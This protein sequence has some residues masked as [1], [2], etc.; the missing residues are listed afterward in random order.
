MKVFWHCHR[1]GF[2]LGI[3]VERAIEESLDLVDDDV[4]ALARGA[5]PLPRPSAGAGGASRRPCARCTSSGVL[6]PLSARVGRARPASCSTTSTTSSPPTSTRCSRWRTSRR[7]RPGQ[8]AESEG[9]ARGA[10]R[11]GAAGPPD[12]RHAAARHRQG[13][14]P[15]PRRQGHPAHRGADRAHRAARRRRGQGRSSW[16]RITSRMSHTAQRRDIDDPKT[17]EALAEVVR[18]A[19]AAAHALPP[20]L[21]RHARGGAGG[22]DGLAGAHPGELYQPHAGPA[23]RRAARAPSREAVAERV[24]GRPCAG[25]GSRR[26]VAA[27]LAMMSERY[28]ATTSPQ[29]IAAHLRLVERLEEDVGRHRALPPSRS[30][31]PSELVIA[32]RD[33]PGL[34]SLIAGTLAAHGI[35]ILS[36]QIHTRAD[37]IAIDTFQV[38]DPFGEAGD[39]GGALAADARRAPPRDARRARRWRPCSRARRGGRPGPARPW[40]GRPRSSVDN[41]L[42]DTPHRRRGEVSRPGRAALRHHAHALRARASTS[43]APGS[44]PRSTR[45]TTPST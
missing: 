26:A 25:E 45:P 34:F 37:G 44:P 14:G 33:V 18:H 31:T 40:R 1:L 35:N 6:G 24:S 29:R 21:R 12:A 32:T 42:S 8:S 43:A 7:W 36:A 41:R 3:D 13:E 19:R 15:R 2:E 5:R 11:R 17:V 28:L 38:N 10:Q 39:R 22:D 9:I 27:H 23:H 30:R 20:H 16:W 4:P